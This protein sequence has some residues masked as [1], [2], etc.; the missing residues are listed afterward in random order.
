[1]KTKTSN[2]GKCGVCKYRVKL[3]DM[4]VCKLKTLGEGP[5]ISDKDTC[6][7]YEYKFAYLEDCEK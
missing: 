1:M 3:P 7:N 2:T 4:V 5:R 6:K